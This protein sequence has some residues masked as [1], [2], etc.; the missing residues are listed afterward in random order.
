MPPSIKTPS[1]FPTLDTTTNII[2]HHDLPRNRSVPISPP[3][4]TRTNPSLVAVIELS[5]LKDLSFFIE[6]VQKYVVDEDLLTC[7]RFLLHLSHDYAWNLA[8][9]ATDWDMMC[10][11]ARIIRLEEIQIMKRRFHAEHWDPLMAIIARRCLEE[12]MLR[13]ATL[14]GW[15]EAVELLGIRPP[16]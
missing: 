11:G 14:M 10:G 3:S 4:A 1:M 7:I 5:A 12:K 8:Y 16:S 6:I 9:F 15:G 13:R 2:S